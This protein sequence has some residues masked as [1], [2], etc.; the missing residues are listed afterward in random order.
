MQPYQLDETYFLVDL[1]E[2]TQNQPDL[3]QQLLRSFIADI[4]LKPL[5]HKV[6]TSEKIQE[7]FR[8]MQQAKHIGKIV[9]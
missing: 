8:Y 4:S 6:F 5:P 3:I 7:A 9:I 1:L 2:V